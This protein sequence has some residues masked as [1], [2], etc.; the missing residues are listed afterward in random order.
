MIFFTNQ[1]YN[2]NKIKSQITE[3]VKETKESI[4]NSK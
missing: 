2:I 1:R 3:K 4:S